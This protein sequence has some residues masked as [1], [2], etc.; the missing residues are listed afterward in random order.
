MQEPET[1]SG[2]TAQG[3]FDELAKEYLARPGVTFGPVF[4]SAGMKIGGKVFALQVR[5]RLVV[6]LPAAQVRA[7]VA[8]GEAVPFEPSPGRRMKEWAAAESPDSP[9]AAVRWRQLMADACTYV[10][11][12]TER[13]RRGSV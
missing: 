3:L 2:A 13:T 6:K 7:L 10:A 4:H 1:Q 9:A 8:A 5:G 12:L 11:A